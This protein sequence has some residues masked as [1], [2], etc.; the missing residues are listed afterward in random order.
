MICHD[1]DPLVKKNA[2]TP[3]H[4]KSSRETHC[5]KQIRSNHGQIY[6]MHTVNFYVVK[7]HSNLANTARALA[8]YRNRTLAKDKFSYCFDIFFLLP[9][10]NF[11]L[12]FLAPRG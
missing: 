5:T 10:N 2:R 9:F 1:P 3:L 4:V 7:Y 8:I 6:K 11:F 12:N